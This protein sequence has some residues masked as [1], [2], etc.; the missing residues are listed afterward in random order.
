MVLRKQV[1]KTRCLIVQSDQGSKCFTKGD[2]SFM[3]AAFPRHNSL[4]TMHSA[5]CFFVGQQKNQQLKKNNLFT[6]IQEPLG[7]NPYCG[8]YRCYRADTENYGIFMVFV[9]YLQH[10]II[11]QLCRR[12]SWVT[13]EQQKT[14]Y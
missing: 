10:Y 13:S 8:C 6:K 2:M 3:I 11:S 12:E 5:P 7:E 4:I 14:A 1:F 9:Q